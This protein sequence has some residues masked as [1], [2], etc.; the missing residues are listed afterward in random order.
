MPVD[1]PVPSSAEVSAL[2]KEIA[3]LRLEQEKRD[4]ERQRRELEESKKK[5]PAKPWWAS[6]LEI[7]ALPAA[8][9]AI[10][11]QFTNASST[12]QT[13]AKTEAETAKIK[14]EEIKTRVELQKMLDDLAET[15]KKGV[16]AYREEIERTLPQLQ[17]TIERLR[18]VESQSKAAALERSIAKYILLWVLFHFVSLIFDIVSQVWS[19]LWSSVSALVSTVRFK[20]QDGREDYDRQRRLSNVTRW[21]QLVL[22]PVP[23]V[24][25]WSLQLSIFIALVIPLFNEVALAIGSRT[26][27]DVV[28]AQARQ[29]EVGAALS[30]MKQLL[31][32]VSP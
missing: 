15:K 32:G 16:T 11:V 4:L 10:V 7:L 21:A 25:R 1:Q 23:S 3:S 2:A 30:T 22:Y 9:I 29:L 28:V 19:A 31:F 6:A 24:L 12:V 20:N 26:S 18:V 14:V 27:F 5:P 8:V 17:Q 13:T